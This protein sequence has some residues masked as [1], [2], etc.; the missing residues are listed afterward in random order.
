MVKPVSGANNGKA[1]DGYNKV[2]MYDEKSKKT[3]TYFV[4]VGQNL[5]VNGKTYNLDKSK[6]SEQVFKGNAEQTK[7]NLM[8][9]ALE[10]MDVNRDG[11]IDTKDTDGNL[12]GKINKDLNNTPYYVKHNDIF[13]DAG[14]NKGEGGVVFSLDGEG[15]FFGVEIEKKNE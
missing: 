5:T 1:P 9:L 2:T 11:R 3:K 15:Q 10:H 12:A 7:F 6:G 8:G 4:P 14:I 13:S